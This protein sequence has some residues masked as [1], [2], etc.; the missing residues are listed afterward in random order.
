MNDEKYTI[1]TKATPLG[2]EK[3]IW[4]HCCG[5]ID[6]GFHTTENDAE[7][8]AHKQIYDHHCAAVEKVDALDREIAHSCGIRL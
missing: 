2:C 7:T 8:W 1:Q 3:T 4:H 6:H 5:K